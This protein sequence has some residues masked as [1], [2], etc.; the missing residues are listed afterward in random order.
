MLEEVKNKLNQFSLPAKPK[1]FG[2]EYFFPEDISKVLLQE[3]GTLMFK[4][5]AWKG[6]SL[7]LLATLDIEKSWLENKHNNKI[8]KQIAQTT[9]EKRITKDNALGQLI[10][11]DEEFRK[12]KEQLII[13]EAEVS[14]L[15]EVVEIYS[16]QIEVCSREV[17]RRSLD[18]QLKQRGI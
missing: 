11:N 4:L 1:T 9:N 2:Q 8:A 12:L 10:L 3:L 18:L 5:A 16:M 7:R 15:R 6:Y 14:S 13:K 17:S